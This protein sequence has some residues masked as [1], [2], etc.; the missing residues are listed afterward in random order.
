M[1]VDSRRS[2]SPASPAT[3][4]TGVLVAMT[5]KEIDVGD[6]VTHSI[7]SIPREAT[8]SIAVGPSVDHSSPPQS[9]ASRF[10]VG[11]TAWAVTPLE[12]WCGNERYG[13]TRIL[14]VCT[15]RP[16]IDARDMSATSMPDGLVGLRVTCPA[17]APAACRGYLRVTT[18][19]PY[20]DA[21]G[22]L[23]TPLTMPPAFFSVAKG[24]TGDVKVSADQATLWAQVDTGDHSGPVGVAVRLRLSADTAGKA[25]VHEGRGWLTV[26][27][28]PAPAP[29]EPAATPDG[30]SPLQAE[31]QSQQVPAAT[32]TPEP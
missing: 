13:W 28:P 14:K 23:T 11:R 4:V 5:A 2:A 6:P 26:P 21:A 20:P 18:E 1:L 17:D 32:P 19:A 7:A 25:V 3:T 24:T 9:L 12:F 27:H 8:S 16:Y 31:G 22:R 30:S 15:G 10:L 29:A